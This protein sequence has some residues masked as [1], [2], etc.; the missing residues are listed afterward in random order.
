MAKFDAEDRRACGL[1]IPSEI[2]L[3]LRQFTAGIIEAGSGKGPVEGQPKADLAATRSGATPLTRDI[4]GKVPAGAGEGPRPAAR[5][6]GHGDAAEGRHQ[7]AE[8]PFI[9]S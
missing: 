9:S 4:A 3:Y 8:T 5:Q 2:E 6:G 7:L 1:P